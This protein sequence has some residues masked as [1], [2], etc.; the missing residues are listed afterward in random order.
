MALAD[1]VTFENVTKELQREG[2][3]FRAKDG[4]IW[5]VTFEVGRT[6]QPIIMFMP[7]EPISDGSYFTMF[8]PLVSEK[9]SGGLDALDADALRKIFRIASGEWLAR[10]DVLRLESGEDMF[11]VRSECS[12]IGFDGGRLRRRMEAVATL[13]AKVE[14]E[15]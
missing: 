12:V 14:S 11:V 5:H 6:K 3:D 4:Q 10:V 15:L 8:S 1:A 2:L 13:A 7:P 9:L